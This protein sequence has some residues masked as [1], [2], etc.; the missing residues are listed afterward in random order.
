M[1]ELR[2]E[3][4]FTLDLKVGEPQNAGV[5]PD[6]HELRIVPVTGG[7]ANGPR[8]RAEVL[9]GASADWLRVETDGTA[10]IDVRLTLRAESGGIVHVRY[11]GIRTGAKEVLARLAAGEAV[12][13]SEYY[14][15]VALRFET[16]APDLAWLNRVV[17]V[18]IG[19]RPPT[20]P[21]Y[22][23]YKLL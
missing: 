17:A 10:H 8:L 9:G 20:G 7:T 4:L 6:G 23:V 2:G 22:E 13:P 16:G 11:S 1:S 14:F 3:H 18:G 15:R 21:R 19:Q 5:G 12:D